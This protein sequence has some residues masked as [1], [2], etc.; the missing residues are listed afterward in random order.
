M[1]FR[2]GTR[3]V[4]EDQL[5]GVGRA[6]SEL[7]VFGRLRI[8]RRPVLDGDGADL[9]VAVVR[10][11]DRG[12]GHPCTHIGARVGDESFATVDDPVITVADCARLGGGGIRSGVGLGES[13]CPELRASH[14]R[15]QPSL[16]LFSGT[17]FHD[18]RDAKRDRR[19][20]RDRA[21]RVRSSDLLYGEAVG[22]EITPGAA[23]LLRKRQCE[24]PQPSHAGD[25]LVR[26]IS[27]PIVLASAG[28]DLRLREVANHVANLTL[29]V[30]EFEVH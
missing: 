9:L 3:A 23:D 28:C 26:K 12:D 25:E 14:Q 13:E 20:K 30:T 19:L 6:P 1:R 5:A 10:A 15:P 7:A 29:F 21:A 18:R 8:P 16:L 11:G 27:S 17:E 4:L 2:A 24:Q 22:D